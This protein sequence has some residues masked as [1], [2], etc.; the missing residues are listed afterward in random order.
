V[1]EWY[2]E[3]MLLLAKRTARTGTRF[4][5]TMTTLAPEKNELLGVGLYSLADAARLSG[6]NRETV[7]RW[8]DEGGVVHRSFPKADGLLTF[9][10]LMEIHFVHI[11]RGAGIPFETIHRTAKVAAEKFGTPY[12]FTV[13]RFDTDGRTIFATMIS[14]TTDKVVIQDLHKGQL[15]FHAIMRPF[16]R[17][18]D[19]GVDGESVLRFWP[20]HK[21]GRVL[22][23]PR[24]RF[25]QPIDAETG[26]PTSAIYDVHMAGS[27]QK[28]AIVAWWL[29]IPIAAVNAAIAF[30]KSLRAA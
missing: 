13:K 8:L 17:K 1:V 29:G 18:L 22:I 6:A 28:P 3:G 23:D 11:F 2:Q 26:V 16:F 15:V 19:Y 12:P 21:R 4:A 10:E 30:E 20:R 9:R 27:G 25:G 24:R 5:R 7:R 14:Q